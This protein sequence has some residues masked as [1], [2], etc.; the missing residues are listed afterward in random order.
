[1]TATVTIFDDG[2]P[3]TYELN[4]TRIYKDDISTTYIFDFTYHKFNYNKHR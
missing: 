4:P 1:M 3:K 2:I